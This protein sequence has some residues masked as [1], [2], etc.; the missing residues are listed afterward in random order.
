MSITSHSKIPANCSEENYEPEANQAEV[1]DHVHLGVRC[2]IAVLFV[3]AFAAFLFL[4]LRGR[5]L[6]N[7]RLYA[8]VGL[9][10]FVWLA[11][12]IYYVSGCMF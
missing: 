7:W 12:S 6:K 10:Y 5:R 3:A 2:F 1:G 11:M 8:L 4:V 9:T